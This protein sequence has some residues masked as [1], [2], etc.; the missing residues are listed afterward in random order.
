MIKDDIRHR[1]LVYAHTPRKLLKF[2]I[3]TQDEVI[4]L[5]KN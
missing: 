4:V 1:T 2:L 5:T 3:L